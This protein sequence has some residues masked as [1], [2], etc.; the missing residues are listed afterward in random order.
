[1][2]VRWGGE[3]FLVVAQTTA[4]ATADTLAQRMLNAISGEP[5]VYEG[6]QIAVTASIGFASFPIA[7]TQLAVAWERAIRLVDAAMYLAKDHGRNRG[8]GVKLLHARDEAGIDAVASE[9]EFACR[10]GKVALTLLQGQQADLLCEA[11]AEW[12]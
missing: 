1:M 11:E 4:G 10:E 12:A 3:E 2:I 7:P 8:Y 9:M 5:V 6:R